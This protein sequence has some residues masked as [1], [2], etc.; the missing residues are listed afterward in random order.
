M[1]FFTS[2]PIL[3]LPIEGEEFT[4]YYDASGVSLGCVLM[5]QGRIIAY[6]LRQLK[7]QEHNYLAH[8]IEFA[9]IVF[10]LNI[11]RHHLYS[12]HCE[13]IMNR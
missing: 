3:A 7:V 6:A 10:G 1:E 11:W 2:T 5:E 8:D 13:I 12:V 4:M 9:A